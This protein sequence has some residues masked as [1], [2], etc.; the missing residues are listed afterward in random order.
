M[1]LMPFPE[2]S[3]LHAST[4]VP[5]F[6][7]RRVSAVPMAL[8]VPFCTRYTPTSGAS[9]VSATV[10]LSLVHADDH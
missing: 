2:L 1:L 6:Q 9:M 8:S 4:T 10:T 7:M 5:T 3:S